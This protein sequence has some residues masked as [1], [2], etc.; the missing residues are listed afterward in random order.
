[1]PVINIVTAVLAGKHQHIKETYTSLTAQQMPDGWEWRWLVQE[2][3]TTG[4][5][6]AELPDNDPRIS[7]SMG[8]AGR[9]AMART[10]AM[11]RATGELTR[12][13][14][15]DDLLPPDALAQD[16]T[17]L[18]ENPD[19]AWTVSPTL[20]LLPDGSFAPGPYDPLPGPL[21][22]GL[23]ADGEANDHLQVVGTTTCTYTS[24]VHALGGWQAMPGGEDV[25]LMLAAEAVG[26]GWMGAKPGLYYRKWEGSTTRDITFAQTEEA[27]IWRRLML[28][29]AAALSTMG[30]NWRQGIHRY[31]T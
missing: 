16:I 26:P 11:E 24:L 29:R 27:R 10:I 7:T 23:L 3:G 20:D 12:A 22:M 21:P 6:A 13:L 18:V 14:D 25:A 9:A 28:T 5:P 30:W 8:R 31:T 4:I 1:M 19:F 17:N 15:A 2:D